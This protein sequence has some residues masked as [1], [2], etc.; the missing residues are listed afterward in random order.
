MFD[1]FADNLARRLPAVIAEDLAYLVERCRRNKQH[2]SRSTYLMLV[3]VFEQQC[4]V[5]DEKV[6]VKKKTG[7]NIICNSSDPDATFD[8]H[9]GSGYQVHLSETCSPDNSVQLIVSAIP[10]T[11]VQS[12]SASLEVVVDDLKAQGMLPERMLADSAYSSDDNEMLCRSE[13]IALV[14]PTT[15]KCPT[16]QTDPAAITVADFRIEDG[17]ATDEYSRSKIVPTCVECPEGQKPHRSFY[18][19][20]MQQINILQFPKV[21]TACPL[22][23]KC[24]V[25]YTDGWNQ[26]TI[27]AKDVRLINRRRREQTPQFRDEYRGGVESTNSILKRVTGLDRLRVRGRPAVFSSILLKVAGWSLLRA[28]SVRSLIAKLAKG[29]RTG[30]TARNCERFQSHCTVSHRF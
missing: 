22:I 21:C 7:G 23:E 2:N 24:P 9:K 30:G 27:K 18:D 4:E 29:G 14:S 15:G 3:R 10:E 5:I 1:V 26:V 13:N 8:G 28:A 6:V 19:D 12:D 20:W 25:R 17:E 11:A 16:E